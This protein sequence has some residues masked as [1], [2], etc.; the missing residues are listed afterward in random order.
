MQSSR[1]S[2]GVVVNGATSEERAKVS[3]LTENFTFDRAKFVTKSK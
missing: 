3:P 1:D 2:N